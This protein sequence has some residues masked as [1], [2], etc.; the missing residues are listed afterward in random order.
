MSDEQLTLFPD[1]IE[2]DDLD[3]SLEQDDDE[4]F[5]EIAKTIGRDFD[6]ELT[7]RS[8]MGTWNYLMAYGLPTKPSHLRALYIQLPVI[9]LVWAIKNGY[10]ELTDKA[11]DTDEERER[12]EEIVRQEQS[13]LNP[14]GFEE[15]PE[16]DGKVLTGNFGQ[17]L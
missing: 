3:D 16:L 13:R 5:L 1:L 4:E 6:R 15:A 12:N 10:V 11:L 2:G 17:Y 14:S 9:M 7:K 8:D